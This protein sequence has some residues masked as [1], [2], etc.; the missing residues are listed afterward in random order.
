MSGSRTSDSEVMRLVGDDV[1][2]LRDRVAVEAPLELRLGARPFTVLMRTP[3]DDEE[4]ARGFL[5][6]EGL[7]TRA[8]DIAALTR[9]EGLSGDEI[10]NVLAIELRPGVSPPPYERVFYSS[11]SCG[12]CGKASIAQLA[13]H[14]SPIESRLTVKHRVLSALPEKLRAAQRVFAETGGLHAAAL[15]SPDGR[16]TCAREDVGRHNAVDKLAGWALAEGRVP[17]GDQVMVVSGRIG[18]EI[19]QKALVAGV[20]IVAAVGAPSSLALELAAQFGLTLV[21]FLRDDAMNVYTRNDR[22]A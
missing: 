6:T 21:G 2:L 10:G 9:P 20:P 17:L 14:A 22:V 8:A 19:V 11:S 18:F 16:L 12:V 1:Q 7:I 3:G 5:F 13:L 4:L 15:F